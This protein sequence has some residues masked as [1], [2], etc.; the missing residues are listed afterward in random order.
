[1]A[2]NLD[3]PFQ[4]LCGT[5]ECRGEVRPDDPERWAP[6]WDARIAA[7]FPMLDQ[8]SQPLWDLVG[9]KDDVRRALTGLAR[10]PSVLTHYLR[11][12]VS[13]VRYRDDR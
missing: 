13:C 2:L 11:P 5:P 4:F 8:I 6:E 3:V 7:A 10:I 9:A 1:M 12:E